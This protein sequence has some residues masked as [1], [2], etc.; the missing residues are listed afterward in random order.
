[1]NLFDLLCFKQLVLSS[2]FITDRIMNYNISKALPNCYKLCVSLKLL[3]SLINSM[4]V[5]IH[6]TQL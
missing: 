6:N 5:N 2:S 4:I 1:M 3:S